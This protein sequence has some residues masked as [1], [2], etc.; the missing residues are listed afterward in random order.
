[1]GHIHIN[2]EPSNKLTINRL[3]AGYIHSIY[4]SLF[5]MDCPNSLFYYY[6]YFSF[7]PIFFSFATPPRPLDRCPPNLARWV[8]PRSPSE[9]ASF[10][11]F[12]PTGHPGA[13]PKNFESTEMVQGKIFESPQRVNCREIAYMM[14]CTWLGFHILQIF[15]NQIWSLLTI[16]EPRTG[17]PHF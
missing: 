2:T 17:T 15:W 14:Y 6:Y 16:L 13:P 11:N 5:K 10:K 8:R 1:M 7:P 9:Q 3:R 12:Y 4:T